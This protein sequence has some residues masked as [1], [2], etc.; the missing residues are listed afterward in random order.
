MTQHPISP[1]P[2][3][4]EKI[5][6]EALSKIPDTERIDAV[7]VDQAR[8]RYIANFFA[9]WGAEQMWEACR[10]E[11]IDGVRRMYISAG[12]RVALADDIGS[13]LHPK[14]PSLKE[15]A[16]E[17]LMTADGPEHPTPMLYL[18]PDVVSIIRR[19]L[20]SIPDPS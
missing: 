6:L 20:E 11:I 15:Q 10:G 1:P 17:A 14:P 5:A 7:E 13:I 19:A 18:R 8:D 4:V 16:L 3:L 9:N 12:S 2:E